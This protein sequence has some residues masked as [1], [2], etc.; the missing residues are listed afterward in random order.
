MTL[1]RDVV[2]VLRD[3]GTPYALIGA[4]AMA[5]YGVSRSTADA[6][7]LTVDP[8]SLR[9]ELWAPFEAR[10]IQVRVVRGDADD[11]LAGTVRLTDGAQTVDVVAGRNAWQRQILDGATTRS[12]AGVQV[13]VVSAAGLILLKLH[14]GGPKDAWDIRSLL[15]AAPDEA[16]LR[17]E[18]ER[19]LAAVGPEAA[20]L[21]VRLQAET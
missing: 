3:Q 20:R 2:A 19:D 14:A 1:L 10:G 17:A 18:V 15:E 21:W 9:R 16:T 7:L 11:P 6:D 12:V 13:P 4:V 5:V 8:G